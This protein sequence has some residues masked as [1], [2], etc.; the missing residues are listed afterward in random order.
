MFSQNANRFKPK[1]SRSNYVQ[2]EEFNRIC[3]EYGLNQT[4]RDRIHHIITKKGFTA[5]MIRQLIEKL[6]PWLVK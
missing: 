6:Y 5:D 1:D 2:N 4:Q 3:N